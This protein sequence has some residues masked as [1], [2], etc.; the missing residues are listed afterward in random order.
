MIH[1]DEGDEDESSNFEEDHKSSERL[2]DFYQAFSEPPEN[3]PY[4]T[5]NETNLRSRFTTESSHEEI[6]QRIRKIYTY[7]IIVL[8]TLCFVAITSIIIIRMT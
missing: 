3:T 8:F 7:I 5:G 6:P 1:I 2:R 4:P